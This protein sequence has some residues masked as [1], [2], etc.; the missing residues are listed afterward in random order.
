M[1]SQWTDHCPGRW[2]LAFDAR[3]AFSVDVRV[4]AD[5]ASDWELTVN[6]EATRY[7]GPQD[8]TLSFKAGRN[9]VRII[10]DASGSDRILLEG[11]LFDGASSVW[12]P[13]GE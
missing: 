10:K 3:A 5:G 6:G 2:Q 12:V 11:R 1:I 7:T 4:L 9:T 8:L 13:W